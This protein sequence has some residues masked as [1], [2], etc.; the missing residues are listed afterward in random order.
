MGIPNHIFMGLKTHPTGGQPGS[1]GND[2]GSVL[3]PGHP[4]GQPMSGLRKR[5][6]GPPAPPGGVKGSP[7]P[8]NPKFGGKVFR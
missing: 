3:H 2:S 7:L 4:V 5:V 6:G 8:I 1:A